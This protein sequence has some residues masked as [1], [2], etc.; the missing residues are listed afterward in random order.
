M[1]KNEIFCHCCIEAT[2]WLNHFVPF[3][4]RKCEE[5]ELEWEANHSELRNNY[6]DWGE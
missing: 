5:N 2:V 3:Y 4:K 1:R 6:G